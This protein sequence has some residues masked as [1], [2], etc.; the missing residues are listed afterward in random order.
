MSLPYW[1]IDDAIIFKPKFNSC[2]DNYLDIISNY[3]I[4]IFSNY[5]DPYQALKNN[6]YNY[7]ND[8]LHQNSLF[9]KPLIKNENE[10]P[11]NN[12]E[13]NMDCDYFPVRSLNNSSLNLT[14]L[15]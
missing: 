12:P 2:L 3:R 14:N 5:N 7:E 11:K 9:N 8:D 4:L 15:K 13:N 1:I 6:K 10:A